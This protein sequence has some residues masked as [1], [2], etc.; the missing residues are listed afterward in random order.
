MKFLVDTG[1]SRG[2][3]ATPVCN[4]IFRFTSSVTPANLLVANMAVNPLT[5]I[6]FQALMRMGVEPVS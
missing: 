2:A 4:K 5:Q 1:P 3:G 6:L